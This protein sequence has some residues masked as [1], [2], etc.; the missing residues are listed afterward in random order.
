MQRFLEVLKQ[1]GLE[2]DADAIADALWLA[3]HMALGDTIAAA[4]EPP[5]PPSPGQQ[6]P[7]PEVYSPPLKNGLLDHLVNQR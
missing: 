4:P 1:A 3:T 6:Q 5:V 7:E 2:L